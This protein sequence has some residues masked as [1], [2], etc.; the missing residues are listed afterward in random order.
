MCL[1]S[2][3]FVT[4]NLSVLTLNPLMQYFLQILWKVL[5]E[6]AK[7]LTLFFFS[8]WELQRAFTWLDPHASHLCSYPVLL[9]SLRT[10]W[11]WKATWT[12]VLARLRNMCLFVCWSW[13]RRIAFWKTSRSNSLSWISVTHEWVPNWDATREPLSPLQTNQ[14]K[15]NPIQLHD[16]SF[17]LEQI[18]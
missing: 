9:V 14:V 16:A 13:G 12:T 3:K 6:L 17:S 4:L 2:C 15:S 5:D 18:F 11:Q 10:M 7:R 8:F 1:E